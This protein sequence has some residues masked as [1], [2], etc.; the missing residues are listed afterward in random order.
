MVTTNSALYSSC[1]SDFDKQYNSKA[2]PRLP[3]ESGRRPQDRH[4]VGMHPQEERE[5]APLQKKAQHQKE[6]FYNRF[7]S[8]PLV[9]LD[10]AD[11]PSTTDEDDDTTVSE[12][13]QRIKEKPKRKWRH[14]KLFPKDHKQ[15]LLIA[16]KN[17]SHWQ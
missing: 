4:Q 7:S 16:Q 13:L 14:S 1:S 6:S 17:Y 12:V 3:T 10:A 8:L 15:F 2:D 9:T 11:S 5:V